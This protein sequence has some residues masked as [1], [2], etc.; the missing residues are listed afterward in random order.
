MLAKYTQEIRAEAKA[1]RKKMRV[2][3]PNA[4]EMI[5]DNYNA[6]VIGYAP[7]ERASEAVCS[8]AVY[9][10]W[11]TLFFLKGAKL[12]DPQ[13]L[14][15]GAGKIVRQIRLSS[16]DDLDAPAVRS[17]I[18]QAAERSSIP[19]RGPRRVIIKLISAKQRPRRP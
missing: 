7:T 2:L 4:I 3:F 6:L 9:P 12:R 10:R 8:I 16:V 13:K 18:A 11:V 5:Y 17:L 1:A 14:L 19:F 15:K